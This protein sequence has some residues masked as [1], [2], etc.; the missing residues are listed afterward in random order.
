MAR[1]AIL[2]LKPDVVL[3]F[4][5]LQADIGR[6]L[7]KRGVPVYIF[8]QRSVAECLQTVRV[9]GGLVGRLDE[10]EHLAE[11][12]EGNLPF[13]GLLACTDRSIA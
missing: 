10:A 8:N 12:L 2:D 7:A 3:G 11:E 6:E 9:I 4:S 13:L 1:E 5:D